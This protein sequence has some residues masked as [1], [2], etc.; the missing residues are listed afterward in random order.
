MPTIY[1]YREHV[2]VGGLV[3]YGVDLRW[4]YRRSA[5]FVRRIL[6]GVP[7]GDPPVEFPNK[8]ALSINLKSA[9]ALGL[10]IPPMLVARADEVIE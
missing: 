10:D 3:S 5:Y 7:P 4:C 6:E 8:M 2:V 9:K 1:G